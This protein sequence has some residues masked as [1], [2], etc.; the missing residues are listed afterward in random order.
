[1]KFA[2]QEPEVAAREIE[3]DI[4]SDAF[5]QAAR[6]LNGGELLSSHE[7]RESIVLEGAQS[8]SD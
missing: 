8:A 1:M 2:M 7:V 5:A 4:A 3:V 6:A